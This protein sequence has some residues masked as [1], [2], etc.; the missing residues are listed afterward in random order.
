MGTDDETDLFSIYI[1]SIFSIQESNFKL[2]E[3]RFPQMLVTKNGS[4]GKKKGSKGPLGILGPSQ[5]SSAL[6]GSLSALGTEALRKDDLS[7]LRS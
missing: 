5:L 1:L 4:P 6:G 2:E 7:T 3:V